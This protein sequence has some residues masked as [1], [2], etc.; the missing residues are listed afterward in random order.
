MTNVPTSRLF[1]DTPRL[2]LV[3][4]IFIRISEKSI[5]LNRPTVSGEI[6]FSFWMKITSDSK[7]LL[8]A[9][10]NIN[11]GECKTK[12]SSFQLSLLLW[13][14]THLKTFAECILLYMLKYILKTYLSILL[15][16]F[17]FSVCAEVCRDPS[18]GRGLK[19]GFIKKAFF[20]KTFLKGTSFR[21]PLNFKF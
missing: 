11:F 12:K 8:C 10:F 15:S 7:I 18:Q 17:Y 21:W 13:S 5:C 14:R 6:F 20:K 19:G 9:T 3:G 2:I 1:R 4:K 16:R